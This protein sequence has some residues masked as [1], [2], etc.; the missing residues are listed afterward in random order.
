MSDYPVGT[1]LIWA[2]LRKSV[3]RTLEETHRVGMTVSA[4]SFLQHIQD[5][6]SA[7]T[8]NVLDLGSLLL[9]GLVGLLQST[10][11]VKA[12][13]FQNAAKL[14]SREG[15][16]EVVFGRHGSEGAVTHTHFSYRTR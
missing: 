8:T 9:G 4:E 15:R 1:A 12:F 14:T 11:L 5:G 3:L 6:L 13:A 7:I 16:H 2:L 10:V